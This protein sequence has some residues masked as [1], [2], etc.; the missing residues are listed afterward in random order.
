MAAGEVV[1][2][3]E[4]RAALIPQCGNQITGQH[5]RADAVLVA[6]CGRIDAM[7]DRL[8]VGV[9]ECAAGQ[10]DV[11]SRQ[12]LEPG[13]RLD[14][15]GAVVHGDG[16]QHARR[17]HRAGHHG[18]LGDGTWLDLRKD[19]I[20][21]Q[22]TCF[23]AREH[24]PAVRRRH[25]DR[26]AVGVGVERNRDLG[27]DI[28][29]Q[30]QQRVDRAGLLRVGERHRGE[31]RI[32]RELALNDVHVGEPGPHQGVHHE[33]AT[34]TVQRRQRHPHRPVCVPDLGRTIDVVL[35][36]LD[37]RRFDGPPRDLVGIGSLCDGTLDL[38][39]DGRN[40]REPALEVDLVAVVGRRVVRRG[41]LD[42]RGR[43]VTAHG[44]RHHGR[45]HRG[46]HQRD[47]KSLGGKDFRCSER[48]V[49]GSMA[50]VPADHH[51]LTGQA[52]GS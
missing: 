38:F 4:H 10:V 29:S 16:G 37:A 3:V 31:V 22:P 9:D 17:H 19:V 7:A 20:T 49:L 44:E 39:V 30:L 43:T 34:H 48:E 14:V 21:Q 23:V 25:P 36:L 46:E 28:G 32:G 24:A 40:D 51:R 8:F 33:L 47:R 45:R 13:E 42:A 5:G 26:A 18:G 50:G 12:P 6:D 27:V 2:C 15:L 1:K 41:D 35:N 11:G 52:M